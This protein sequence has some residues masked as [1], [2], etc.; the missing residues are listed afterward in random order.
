M[1]EL[2]R[3]GTATKVSHLLSHLAYLCEGYLEKALNVMAYLQQKHNT[4]LI[5]D[6]T[7][8]K[9]NMDSFPQLD[10]TKFYGDVEE[11]IPVDMP[12]PL[13]K[14]V[15]VR[16]M[17]DC[18]HA[19]NKGTRCFCTGFLIFFDMALIDWVSKKQTTIET[20]VFGAEFIAMKNGIKKLQGLCYKLGMMGI[21]LTGPSFIFSDNK[22]QVTNSTRPDSTLKK[23]CNSICYHA[24]QESVAMS[25]SL[26]TH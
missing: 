2:G 3:I 4:Q 1:V 20:S 26:I 6:P 18:D 16:M 24:V 21:P 23:K 14:D 19:G 12:E 5:F 10:W 25:A 11:A 15:D 9:I 13:G 7:Y 17:H 22:S 8:S